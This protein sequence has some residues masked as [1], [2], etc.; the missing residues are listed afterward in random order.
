MSNAKW[1]AGMMMT[2]GRRIVS[3]FERYPDEPSTC[4]ASV[5]SDE[6]ARVQWCPIAE[7]ERYHGEPDKND[8]ATAAILAVSR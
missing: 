8:L 7:F 5:G 3:V 4:I 1:I 2:T 6:G